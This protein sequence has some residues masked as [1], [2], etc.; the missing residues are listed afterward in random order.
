MLAKRIIPTIL[1]KGA[2]VV[3]GKQFSADRIVGN[4]MQTV[5]VYNLRWVDELVVFD[6]EARALGRC[7]SPDFVSEIASRNFVPLTVGGGIRSVGQAR[8]L[9]Q[10]GA[11]K[12][13][14]GYNFGKS[15]LVSEIASALGSQ[16]IAACI[17]YV[18]PRDALMFA[19]SA[20][21]AGAGEII[22]QCI[23]RDG[24]MEGYDLET[25]FFVASSV[26]IPVVLSGGAGTYEHLWQGLQLCDA[27]AAAAMWTF[28]DSTPQEAKKYLKDKGIEVRIV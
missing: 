20:Q 12:V 10:N 6:V 24:M 8:Q 21:K 18:S 11:D 15:S 19:K 28:T 23:A 7:I 1:C 22:L 3:K 14:V 5:E 26:D 4:V 17:N 13:S 2:N 25:A 16:A 27:V 9:I